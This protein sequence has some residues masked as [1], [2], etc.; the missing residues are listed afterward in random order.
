MATQAAVRAKRDPGQEHLYL[1]VAC[2]PVTG[3]DR[4]VV[5]VKLKL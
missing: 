5:R 2:G 4:I 1:S 3:S